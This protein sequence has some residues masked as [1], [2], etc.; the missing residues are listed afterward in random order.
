MVRDFIES[1][2][3]VAAVAR[4]LGISKSAVSQWATTNYIPKVRDDYFRVA[5]PEQYTAHLGDWSR[6]SCRG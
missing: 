3:G 5:Y 2:G 4:K 1:L 6:R